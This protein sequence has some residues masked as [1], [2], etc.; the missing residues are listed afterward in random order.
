MKTYSISRYEK[1]LDHDGNIVSIFLAVSISD[2]TEGTYYEHWLSQEEMVLVL[3]DESNLK[4]ILEKC[5]AEA[6]L[7]LENEVTTRPMPTIKP[8]EEEGK[9][10][11]LEL[12]VKTKDIATAKT[13]IVAEKVR[14]EEERLAELEAKEVIETSTEEILEVKE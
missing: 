3:A 8:L 14:I 4:P 12:L 5:Y 1:N 6:E 10:E 13:A 7:K 9:K 11:T 2:G